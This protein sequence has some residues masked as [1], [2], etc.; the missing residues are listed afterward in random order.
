MIDEYF[1]KSIFF[2]IAI[3]FSIILIENKNMQVYIHICAISIRNI[4][5]FPL[6][7]L[8]KIS[9]KTYEWTFSG[10]I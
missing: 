1:C 8:K 4:I 7:F 5:Y 6:L 9:G 2:S 3:S 10:I